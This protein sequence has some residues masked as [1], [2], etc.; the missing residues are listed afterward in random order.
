MKPYLILFLI[1]LFVSF[2]NYSWAQELI[3][4][5][6]ETLTPNDFIPRLLSGSSK[7]LQNIANYEGYSFSWRLRSEKAN[8]A[9]VINGINFETNNYNWKLAPLLFGVF[10]SFNI[11][12]SFVNHESAINSYNK[13]QLYQYYTDGDFVKNRTS[14]AFGFSN[15]N[16]NSTLNIQMQRPEF[17]KNWTMSFHLYFQT[18]PFP[19][20]PMGRKKTFSSLLS[21]DKKWNEKNSINIA[22]WATINDQ[23]KRSSSVAETFYLT[24]SKTYNP[25][26]GW[27]HQNILY[28]NAKSSAIVVSTLKHIYE[29]GGVQINNSM[30]F[31]LGNQ[32]NTS[33]EWTNTV[34]PRPDYYRYLPS[35]SKD[36]NMRALLTLRYQ[37]NPQLLQIDF[38]K[39]EKI[40]KASATERSFYIINETINAALLLRYTG[41]INYIINPYWKL[42]AGVNLGYT[43]IHQY[44]KIKDL[45]GGNYYLNYNSWINDDGQALSMQN[46]QRLPD[47]KIKLNEK[48][49]P[50]FILYN[51]AYTLWAQAANISKRVETNFGFHFNGDQYQ[52]EGLNQNG[53]FKSNSLG[54]SSYLFFPSWG[55][56]SQF[57]LKFTGRFYAKSILFSETETPSVNQIYIDPS[58]HAFTQP[59][60]YPLLNKGIDLSF[61][62]RAPALKIT[63]T[64]FCNTKA[65]EGVQKMFYH[66]KY[67]AFV[68]GFIGGI[69]NI[70]IGGEFL[71]ES[72]LWQWLDFQLASTMTKAE[73]SND[74]EYKIALINDLSTLESGLLFIKKLPTTSSPSIV[75]ALSLQT[76]SIKG[77]RIGLVFI[78]AMHKSID[79]DLFRRSASVYDHTTPIQWNQI[80]VPQFLKDEWLANCFMSKSILLKRGASK[81]PLI[82]SVSAKNLLNKQLPV[83]VYEQSRFD[84]QNYEVKKFPLKYIYDQ[85][86]VFNLHLQFQLL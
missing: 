60:L 84:Y 22:L 27:F 17:Y 45:L 35:Y 77:I 86:L 21:L 7:S 46:E 70:Q 29:I 39:M 6:K 18:T 81:Y 49:G 69:N 37:D 51:T 74:P 62:Y 10:N 2:S 41:T 40:N 13:G 12:E 80:R 66:D 55:W 8:G 19:T 1:G 14:V 52:R 57:L 3:E 54:K 61:F 78:S 44:Q 36:S 58:L 63:L 76:N 28:P 79:Y 23:S 31:A 26:W 15:R 68:Y 42:N 71:L 47:Q 5:T 33:L 48:W 25:A 65:Q 56:Q 73:Y 16:N 11:K 83:L 32:S 20:P 4:E 75:N 64:A 30:G 72:N 34:D 50:S 82:I 85:G 38:D 43:Q 53:L 67:N 59:F 24:K 9:L